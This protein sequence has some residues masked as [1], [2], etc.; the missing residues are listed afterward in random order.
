[1]DKFD[2]MSCIS[3]QFAGLQSEKEIEERADKIV[4]LVLKLKEM[5]KS[6]LKAGI[7]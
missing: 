3:D 1:M 7:L 5:S 6:Y 4:Q 2:F